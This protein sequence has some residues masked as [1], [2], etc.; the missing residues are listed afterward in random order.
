MRVKK[1]LSVKEFGEAIDFF[2][3]QSTESQLRDVICVWARDVVPAERQAFLSRLSASQ[4]VCKTDTTLGVTLLAEIASVKSELRELA[5]REPNWDRF[6]G[7]DEDDLGDFC[8]HLAPVRK[9]FKQAQKVFEQHEFAASVSA[10][11]ELFEIFEIRN[12]ID[13]GIRYYDLDG[14]DF[15]E[16]MACYLRSVYESAPRSE[17]AE[18]L[19]AA[20]EKMAELDFTRQRPCLN[21]IVNIAAEPLSAFSDFLLD[22]IDVVREKRERRYDAWLREAVILR[23]G[24]DGIRELALAEG[25][26]RPRAYLDWLSIL[27]RESCFGEAIVA[28]RN[29]LQVLPTGFP[30]RAAIADVLTTSGRHLDLHEVEMEG[31]WLSFEAKPTL[32]KLL[33]MSERALP[34]ERMS[35][36]RDACEVVREHMKARARREVFSDLWERDDIERQEDIRKNLLV[37]A[38]LLAGN[39]DAAL[40]LAQ[41]DSV[42]GWSDAD[43]AQPLCV[44]FCF[45]RACGGSLRS[46]PSSVCDFWKCVTQDGS[47]RVDIFCCDEDEA[48]TS[49]S[50][51][52]EQEYER[53]FG[54]CDISRDGLEWCFQISEERVCSILSNHHRRAYGR[55]ALLMFAMYETMQAMS[56]SSDALQ[57]VGR[58]KKRFPRHS[59]FWSEFRARSTSVC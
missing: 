9:L 36:M 28:A 58:I 56:R 32:L 33:E 54:L 6:E 53:F 26:E 23:D 46:I 10:Y 27:L 43:N 20:M 21:E 41:T 37:H 16:V 45:V 2:L 24:K 51:L 17:R 35:L 14:I 38:Y 25:L 48:P 39:V 31:R 40:K 49:V 42:L 5:K 15:G 57:L 55:G 19:L 34:E 52:L 29:A 8:E 44:A 11:V 13:Q 18:Q 1:T 30:I 59:A 22:W 12:E 47:S 7:R 50:V 4:D 3:A